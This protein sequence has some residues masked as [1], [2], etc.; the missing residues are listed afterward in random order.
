M[1]SKGQLRALLCKYVVQSSLNLR[2]ALTEGPVQ[3][4][5]VDLQRAP[6]TVSDEDGIDAEKEKPWHSQYHI[7]WVN[8]WWCSG[9]KQIFNAE[10]VRNNT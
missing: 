10:F 3:S 2:G 4:N 9:Q 1:A 7:T 6:P 8:R 5:L